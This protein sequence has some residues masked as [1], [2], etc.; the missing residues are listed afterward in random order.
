[1]S[2]KRD[3]LFVRYVDKVVLGIIGILCLCLLWVFVLNSS[4]QEIDGKKLGPGEIDNYIE[5][6]QARQLL[7][8]L[9]EAP[10]PKTYNK[11]RAAQFAEKFAC[12]INNISDD[13]YIS[14][15]CYA[16]KVSVD[17]RVYQVPEIGEIDDVAVERVRSVAYVPVEPIGLNNPYTMVVTE[18]GDIDFVT[19]EASFDVASLY[20]NFG[21]RF[22]GRAVR[23]DWH[24]KNLAKPVFAVVE[25]ERRRMLDNS[26]FGDWQLVPRTKID[27]LK[28]MLGDIPEKIGDKHTVNL[29]MVKFD[30]FSVQKDILQPEAYDFAASNENWLTPRFHKEY[31]KL[32]K[33]E[34]EKLRKEQQQLD[35]GIGGRGGR[36]GQA[37]MGGMTGGRRGTG[38]GR[39]GGGGT[40]GARTGAS[41]S[42]TRDRRAGTGGRRDNRGG[43]T[44]AR[45]RT[46]YGR[47]GTADSAR[48]LE[49]DKRKKKERKAED[50]YKDFQ[51]VLMTDKTKLDNKREPLVFWAHDDTVVPG[52]SYQY[53]IRLGVFNPIAGR[54]WF[55]EDQQHFKEEPILWSKYSEAT[56]TVSVPLMMHFFPLDVALGEEK[57]VQIKVAKYHNGKWRSEDFKVRPGEM[58]GKVVEKQLKEGQGSRRLSGYGQVAGGS[59]SDSKEVVDYSTGAAL[60]DVI[61]TS[62]WMGVNVLRQRDY[63]DVLYTKD[64]VS[65]EH[66]AVKNRNWPTQLQQQFNVIKAAESEIVTLR[67]R[68]SGQIQ[69]AGQMGGRMGGRGRMG[70]MGGRMGRMGGRMG[71]MG[72]RMG[73]AGGSTR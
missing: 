3:N 18:L 62:D 21:Q 36:G 61:Q 69:P 31:A 59:G 72:G 63:A 2:K 55:R 50:V 24:D 25:L 11:D 12:S 23:R 60:V 8:R 14:I 29:L 58:I 6:Q 46:D 40:R 7:S 9:E 37:G 39:F 68:G 52:K 10:E 57:S 4:T 65:I 19:V 22:T 56:E 66:L 53:R 35:K 70:R 26:G 5:K 15:P 28:D 51:K 49:D 38:G 64:D 47:S 67:G 71:R 44:N 33:A 27:Y 42:G 30:E 20:K 41:A 45:T 32:L 1:M 54:D 13:V 48:A 43:R 16:G 73:G 34:E 17:S